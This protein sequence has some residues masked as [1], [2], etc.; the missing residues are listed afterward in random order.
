MN[1]LVL[2]LQREAMNPQTR[3]TDL[4]RKAIVVASKL[5]IE[6]FNKW[7]ENELRGYDKESPPSYRK[8]RG[9]LKAHNPYRGLIPVILE[10]SKLME[11]L[12]NRD[13]GQSISGLEDLYHRESEG[14][15]QVP[16]PHDVMMKIFG[17]SEEFQLGIIP[18][19][20]VGREQI[21]GILEAVRD[22]VLNWSLELERQ[23]ILGE[24]MTFS[25]EEVHKA[26]NI[27]YNIQN[28]S[29][30]LGNVTDSQVQIGDYNSIHAQLK[31]LGVS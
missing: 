6:D 4:L 20:I 31:E 17:R 13:I 1:S 27:T 26:S 11:K 25:K 19:L 15:L 9:E 30:V 2:D 14:V 23:G 18:T 21:F 22:E 28:F 3:V 24:A 12:R 29:G 16:L 8:V 7:A 10:D 5:G